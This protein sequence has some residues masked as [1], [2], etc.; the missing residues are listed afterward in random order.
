MEFLNT[1]LPIVTIIFYLA[2]ILTFL[3]K[4]D[5]SQK[6]KFAF[7]TI[8]I[9]LTVYYFININSDKIDTNKKTEN[10]EVNSHDDS[11][12]ENK[13]IDII[14]ENKSS[15][16]D[17][18]NNLSVIIYDKDTLG[19]IKLP[20]TA[21]M[22]TAYIQHPIDTGEGSGDFLC[23]LVDKDFL[24]QNLGGYIDTTRKVNKRLILGMADDNDNWTL[25]GQ[26]KYGKSKNKLQSPKR[27]YEWHPE[28]KIGYPVKGWLDF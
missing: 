13:K 28:D 19:F 18:G 27:T 20:S 4:T 22:F 9:I 25:G 6:W 10:Q 2:A 1:I 23:N 3:S 11:I 21:I 12:I 8:A 14:E 5:I 15:Y 26:V 7:L 16:G 24:L 17:L